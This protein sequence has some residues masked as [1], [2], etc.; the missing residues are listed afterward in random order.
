MDEDKKGRKVAQDLKTIYETRF[1]GK[2]RG[3]YKISR[4]VLAKLVGPRTLL[5]ES[6]LQHIIQQAFEL[7]FVIANLEDYFGVIEVKV[8]MNYRPVPKSVLKELVEEE[9]EEEEND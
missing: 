4:S 5:T 1:G 3:R 7:G 8:M 9:P 6:Q 2:R